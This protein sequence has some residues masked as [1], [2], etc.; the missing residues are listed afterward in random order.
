MHARLRDARLLAT[1][2]DADLVV[3][4]VPDQAIAGAARALPVGPWVAHVSGATPLAALDPHRRRFS[5]HPLQ[6]FVLGRGADQFDGAWAAVT[7]ENDD[8]E[9]RANWLAA[10]LGLRA[11]PLADDR[12]ALYHAGAALASNYLVTLYRAAARA[13]AAAGA[14]PEALIPLMRRTI[15]NDFELTGPIARGD[16]DTVRAHVEALERELPDLGVA[17]P[18][19]RRGHAAMIVVRT[20]SDLRAHLRDRRGGGASVG[21]VPTMGALHAGHAALMRAARAESKIAVASLFVNPRQFND[22]ADLAA[23][24]RREAEDAAIAR[25]ESVDLLFAPA[26][27]EIYS[28]GDAT[29][30]RVGGPAEGFEGTARPGH[31]EGV[32]TV[33][34]KLFEIVRPDRGVFRAEGRAAGGR[35]SSTRPRHAPRSRHPRR[36]DGAR[37]R[38]AGV[39]VAQHPAVGWGADACGGDSARVAGRPSRLRKGRRSG[40]CRP[41]V[42]GRSRGRVRGGGDVRRRADPRGGRPRRCHATD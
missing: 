35:D 5:V 29:S 2:G 39:V 32:A 24:P 25:A 28:R 14:P 4:C 1:G 23:Y 13:A 30:V 38:R 10:R 31:F 12:R 6:T 18:R 20:V 7:A 8:A 15:D 26:E 36:P 16:W 27:T 33:C 37:S 40:R 17:L 21:F 42:P 11:F 41:P 9:R 34:L 22:R 3:L 19:A